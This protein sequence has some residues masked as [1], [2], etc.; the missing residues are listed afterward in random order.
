MTNSI[1]E[2]E[3][4]KSDYLI[5]EKVDCVVIRHEPFGL[6]VTIGN[7]T[8]IGL[9]ERVRMIQDGYNPPA[10]YPPI[11][12]Q[13]TATVLGFRDYSQQIELA[14]PQKGIAPERVVSAEEF[15]EVGLRIGEN[16]QLNFFGV[17]DVNE[18]IT[19]GKRV[20]RIE[21]GRAL[22]VK[23]GETQESV[24]IRLQGFSI[25]VVIGECKDLEAYSGRQ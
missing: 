11:G 15:V 14:M 17:E 25:L 22:M 12:S 19:S 18:M 21:E 5:G 16:G 1:K 4:T 20:V 8:A 10:D 13:I 2:W 23:S 9:I 7:T 24:K 6:F 3:S